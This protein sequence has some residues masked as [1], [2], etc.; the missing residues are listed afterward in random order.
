MGG[1]REDAGRRR[2]RRP[3]ATRVLA[4]VLVAPAWGLLLDSSAHASTPAQPPSGV[5]YVTNLTTNTVTAINVINHHLTVI[6]GG[7]QKF[8]GPLGI[9]IA[10]SGAFAYVTNSLANTVTPLNLT[11]NPAR[12]EAPIPVGNGPSAIAISTNGHT[13]YVTNF[14]SNTVT[15]ID[16]TK[17]PARPGM[18]IRVGAGPWS[19]A[20]SPG[21]NTVCVSDSEDSTVSV[22]NVATGK[23]TTIQVGSRPSAIAVAPSGEAAYVATTYGV[24]RINLAGGTA[25]L[26]SSLTVAGGPVGVA[27]SPDGKTAY[28]ANND[29]TVTRINLTTS[30]ATLGVSVPVA[31][32][33]QPDGIAISPDGK[34]AYAAN[35]SNTVTPI[36]LTTT[37]IHPEAPFAVGSSTFGIAIA[38][39]QAPTA[40]LTVI[41]APAGK[42]T[43]FDASKSTSP[44]GKILHYTWHFG[45]GTTAMTTSPTTT[46]VYAR[47]GAYQASVVVTSRFGTST[48][49]TF[50]GQTM[51][52]NGS[53]LARA[54]QTFKVPAAMETTPSHGPPGTAISLRDGS[55]TDSCSPAYVFFDNEL[56]AQS[57]ATNHVLFI[58]QLLIPGNA[59]LGWHHL[60]LSCSTRHS[61]LVSTRFHVVNTTNHLSEFSVAMPTFKELKGHLVAAGGIGLGM[62]LLS[63]LLSAGFPSEW[64]DSTYEA[65]RER[66][67]GRLKRRF[68]RFFV[69]HVGEYSIWHRFLGGF[70]KLTAFVFAAGAINSVLDPG[71]GFNRTTLWLFF[72]QALGVGG[73][74][75]ASQLPIMFEG[76][77][78]KRTVHLRILAGGLIIA[79]VCVA[80]SRLVGLSPGYCYGLIAVYWLHPHVDEKEWGRFHALS[81]VTMML[82]STGAFFLTPWALTHASMP[83]PSPVW[84]ILVP[85]L[86]VLFIGGFAS[87]AFG[88]F[89]LPFLPG[90]HIKNWS[91]VAWLGIT[92]VSLVAFVAV[93]LCKG[94]GSA[95][96]LKHVALVPL[97]VAF[98]VFAIF[99]FGVMIYFHRHPSEKA[100]AEAGS[101]LTAEIDDE[102]R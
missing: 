9:A 53:N 61:W 55:F 5:V 57:S 16:L 28:T 2:A 43:V 22:I 95:N 98:A 73:V 3:F 96:E 89:P 19:L 25:T 85:A 99:S 59:T 52:N 38:P 87:V 42:A 12:L 77:G 83:N 47:G 34:T 56:I 93:L 88:M 45:D 101:A 36:N 92:V 76:L 69:D 4:T 90:R 70:T 35:A 15:P 72:G 68:P 102:L 62:L 41:P 14:N 100:E 37:P 94:S 8:S 58:K 80:V 39:D 48:A 67:F 20:I 60:E 74:T 54:T 97:I 17:N 49:R 64:L 6:R 82:V 31:T 7:T 91:R 65:N 24:T 79:I 81:S 21:G 26:G 50:T 23:V 66:M 51:S 63:S 71:F 86:D 10:P 46:H 84:L 78:Q 1:S 30:P 29:N 32:L 40:R 11:T 44:D 75:M 18:A 13:A 33:S 27:I